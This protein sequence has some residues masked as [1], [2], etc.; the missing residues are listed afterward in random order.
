MSCA[1]A[2]AADEPSL[3]AAATPISAIAGM[4]V[5]ETSTPMSA[6]D[7]AVVRD[8]IPATPAQAATSTEY[9]S[10]LEMSPA[11]RTL[12]LRVAMRRPGGRR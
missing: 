9:A 10:G 12:V 7:L 3:F 6:P 4:A 2:P 1:A 8:S 11:M 5:T